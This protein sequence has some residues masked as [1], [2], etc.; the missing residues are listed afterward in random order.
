PECFPDPLEAACRFANDAL[1]HIPVRTLCR[2][3]SGGRSYLY[4]FRIPSGKPGVRACH[5]VE[6][7][8]L[9]G[10]SRYGYGGKNMDMAVSRRLQEL[11]ISFARGGVPAAEGISWGE[12]ACGRELVIDPGG[13]REEKAEPVPE[14]LKDLAF[15]PVLDAGLF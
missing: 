7:S 6:L 1:F 8:Y 4:S 2:A 10:T 9:F 12:Y 5:A 11:W 3:R 15:I 13:F 14:G